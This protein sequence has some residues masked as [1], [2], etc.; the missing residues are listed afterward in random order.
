MKI[1]NGVYII[2]NDGSY[3]KFTK[4]TSIKNAKLVGIVDNEHSFA[5]ST[6]NLEINR[7]ERII[8]YQENESIT[9]NIRTPIC[10]AIN[11]WNYVGFTNRIKK[12][13]PSI[14]LKKNEYIPTISALIT[15][16]HYKSKG[17]DTALELIGEPLFGIYWS[18]IELS[19][20]R[21]WALY[22]NDGRIY[23]NTKTNDYYVRTIHK[24]KP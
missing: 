8:L 9:K 6:K 3:K 18:C 24:W 23:V 20:C 1:N 5:V 4:R 22:W 19:D 14:T 2:Y 16:Y 10:D 15:M 17:L 12:V 21:A 13:N 11:E 7:S